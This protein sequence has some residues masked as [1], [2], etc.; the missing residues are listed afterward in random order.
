[1][2]WRC[3]F[4]GHDGRCRGP[5]A[6]QADLSPD[7]LIRA[8]GWH[9]RFARV[10]RIERDHDVALVLVD[11]NGNGAE[12]EEEGWI[13]DGDRWACTA[14]NGFGP[15]DGEGWSAGNLGGGLV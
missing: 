13:R 8:G 5:T 6:S 14:S 15:L 9:P 3:P 1:V 4:L 11:G 12:L 10:L 2:E 7:E